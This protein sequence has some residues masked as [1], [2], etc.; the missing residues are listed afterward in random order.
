M[1]PSLACFPHKV[2]NF[3]CDIPTGCYKE[4][5]VKQKKKKIQMIKLH[6]LA[7]TG[8]RMYS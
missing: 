7:K 8:I 2:H 3:Q 1:S 4:D 6:I 5:H